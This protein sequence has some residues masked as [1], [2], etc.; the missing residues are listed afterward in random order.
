MDLNIMPT[1]KS[2]TKPE[3]VD[4]PDVYIPY[5]LRIRIFLI[6]PHLDLYWA[7]S[8]R[9][10]F[11]QTPL[12]LHY[13]IAYEL[14][15]PMQIAYNKAAHSFI[16]QGEKIDF[17]HFATTIE[18]PNLRSLTEKFS[19]YLIKLSEENEADR[20][21]DLMENAIE[22]IHII[23]TE[24]DLNRQIV[25]RKIHE[26][27]IYAV[28]DIVRQKPT[29]YV[30]ENVRH[31]DSEAIKSYINE[32]YL[33]QQLLGIGFHT[34]RMR[35]LM[36]SKNPFINEYMVHVQRTRQLSI[37]HTSHY[38][39]AIAPSR[40]HHVNIFSVRRFLEE[41]RMGDRGYLYLNAALIPANKVY[42]DDAI[43]RFIQQIGRIYTVEGS[44]SKYIIDLTDRI[45]RRL[46]HENHTAII[47]TA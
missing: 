1:P 2:T 27:F 3:N 35:E 7:D 43:R 24:N 31:I 42:E 32:V 16:F 18:N 38:Y 6:N 26:H 14:L 8:L 11:S 19:S 15:K 30:K 37:V 28:A 41:D 13:P 20:F 33:K 9:H 45:G 23:D 12:E 21:I 46:S 36:E 44:V 10:I 4:Y 17:A 39:F 25:K 29:F 34:L 47:C 40:A 5:E 22:Q